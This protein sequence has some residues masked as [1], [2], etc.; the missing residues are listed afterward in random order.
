MEEINYIYFPHGEGDGIPI[1]SHAPIKLEHSD[2]TYVI[3]T[4]TWY[5]RINFAWDTSHPSEV[6]ER[7][8]TCVLL[9]GY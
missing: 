7:L 2:F 1:Y 9:L 4:R 6:S 5:K 3:E 8:K